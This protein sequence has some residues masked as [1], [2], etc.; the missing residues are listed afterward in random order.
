MSTN[1][2]VILLIF[3][4]WALVS[5]IAASVYREVHGTWPN[6]YNGAL[7]WVLV[8]PLVP[9]GYMLLSFPWA[10]RLLTRLVLR[11]VRRRKLP[12]AIVRKEVP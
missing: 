5:V 11:T 10:V 6:E 1:E 8:W 3:T 9:I 7:L 12:R 4:S 2:V